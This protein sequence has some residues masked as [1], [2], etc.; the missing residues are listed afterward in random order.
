MGAV[1]IQDFQTAEK[2]VIAALGE[3]RA[4]EARIRVYERQARGDGL[5]IEARVTQRVLDEDDTYVLARLKEPLNER[6]QRIVEAVL[7]NA[8]IDHVGQFA[9]YK[10]VADMLAR[11]VSDDKGDD[12]LLQLFFAMLREAQGEE[13][14]PLTSVERLAAAREMA[15]AKARQRLA[16][17]LDRKRAIDG[18]LSELRSL[19]DYAYQLVSMRYIDGLD[20]EEVQRKLGGLRNHGGF[21]LTRKE[22]LRDRRRA[23]EL[24]IELMPV[25]EVSTC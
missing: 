18:A 15:I 12:E 5:L 4:I 24:L 2:A 11:T 3:Y 17:Y 7:K 13:L 9:T 21:P 16:Y 1:A 8:P 23:M 22:W 14:V 6:Q 10:R 20:L 25:M 19:S